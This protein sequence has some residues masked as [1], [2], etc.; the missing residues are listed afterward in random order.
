[1]TEYKRLQNSHSWEDSFERKTVLMMLI[2][3]GIQD[4][5][6]AIDE[7]TRENPLLVKTAEGVDVFWK[8]QTVA[9]ALVRRLQEYK[10]KA[11]SWEEKQ[12]GTRLADWRNHRYPSTCKFG[13]QKHS[14][15]EHDAA[16]PHDGKPAV[17][18][19]KVYA[20]T[21]ESFSNAE[22]VCDSSE[23]NGSWHGESM[24]YYA[25][26][27]QNACIRFGVAKIKTKR[28]YLYVAVTWNDDYDGVTFH[29]KDFEKIKR[30]KTSLDDSNNFEYDEKEA[31]EEVMRY[32]DRIAEREAEEER[33]YQAKSSAEFQIEELKSTIET[34]RETLRDLLKERRDAKRN[35]AELADK[36][37]LTCEALTAKA[38][39]LIAEIRE[40]KEKIVK[41]EDNF[42]HAVE[43][44]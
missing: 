23:R 29:M 3:A 15:G 33:E 36:Y 21:V 39:N 35:L 43:G 34:G 7:S 30:G 2:R 22:L 18:T 4:P 42:W 24:G 16:F 31:I 11:V 19:G 20:D 8:E 13:T 27:F 28:F 38:R 1:M 41:L 40:S 14:Y 17:R 5:V 9:P 6:R 10:K 32:A 12:P 37:P 25:D 44:F 26:H